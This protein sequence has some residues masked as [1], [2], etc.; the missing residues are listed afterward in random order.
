MGFATDIAGVGLELLREIGK[1]ILDAIAS[2]DPATLKKV[3][4]VLPKGSPLRSRLALL[5]ERKKA[6]D[7]LKRRPR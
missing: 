7:E 3:G 2:K 5:V 1:L 4:D 6:E